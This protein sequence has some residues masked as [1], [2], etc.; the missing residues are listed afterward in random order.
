MKRILSMIVVALLLAIGL[1][2]TQVSDVTISQRQLPVC[3]PSGLTT[4]LAYVP[5]EGKWHCSSQSLSDITSTAS[6]TV[7]NTE[8]TLN[9]VTIP[10]G[11]F[12]V[13]GRSLQ[14]RAWGTLAANANAKNLKFYFGATAVATV[15]GST[16]SGTDYLAGL[17]IEKIGASAQ[18]GYAQIAP[19]TGTAATYAVSAAIAEPDTAPIVISFKSANTAA[20]AASATGKGLVCDWVN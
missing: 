16:N 14:C 11:H 17:A 8:Y 4:L 7:Q 12:N 10:T 1:A 18:S 2:H 20:A 3:N 9:S 19:G 5:L 6:G 13:A 15:T